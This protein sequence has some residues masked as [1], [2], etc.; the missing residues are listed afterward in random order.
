MS[1]HNIPREDSQNEGAPE[2]DRVGA[3]PFDIRI[4]KINNSFEYYCA[5]CMKCISQIFD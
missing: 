5:I 4:V 1:R 3:A 2:I